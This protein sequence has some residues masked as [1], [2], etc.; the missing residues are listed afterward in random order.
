MRSIRIDLDGM[1]IVNSMKYGMCSIRINLDRYV[2]G[3]MMD[4]GV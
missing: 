1:L 2:I 3:M 4:D